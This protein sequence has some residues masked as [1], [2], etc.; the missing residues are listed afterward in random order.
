MNNLIANTFGAVNN[1]PNPLSF[2][3]QG[4]AA[5]LL[6]N[7]GKD[8]VDQV[9]SKITTALFSG[10]LNNQQ[11]ANQNTFGDYG[12][13]GGGNYGNAFGQGN[14][15]ND[16]LNNLLQQ[17]LQQLGIT[18]QNNPFNSGASQDNVNAFN[19]GV[20]DG[21]TN[22]NN[23]GVQQNFPFNPQ[24]NSDFNQVGNAIGNQVGS[25]VGLEALNDV[26]TSPPKGFAGN[27]VTD[28]NNLSGG[29]VKGGSKETREEIGKF[30]DQHPEV[31]GKPHS[32][33]GEKNPKS[34]EDALKNSKP[35]SNES[36]Q[37]F[38]TAKNDLKTSLL[39]GTVP[40]PFGSA[41]GAASLLN[42][43]AQLYNSNIKGDA[44]KH[45]HLWTTK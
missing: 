21:L 22:N 12:N 14:G 39:G 31:F 5:N 32:P 15:G 6:L 16:L 40:A 27:L 43:D 7:I 44:I 4:A 34:W 29:S 9:A 33:T 13:N 42:A 23:F 35:L 41:P 1:L 19:Q 45:S 3:P 30:M 2:T 37:Q 11:G 26:T 38:Q 8:V 36:L 25:K 18:P 20:S 17:V 24:S 10:A 28:A